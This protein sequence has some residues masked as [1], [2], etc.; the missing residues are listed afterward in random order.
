[1]NHQNRLEPLSVLTS[2][3]LTVIINLT[4]IRQD[5]ISFISKS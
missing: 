1:M 5:A 4:P 2:N 3:I